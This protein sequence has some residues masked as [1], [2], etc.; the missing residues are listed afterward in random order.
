VADKSGNYIIPVVIITVVYVNYFHV[1]IINRSV[2]FSHST[3]T[4]TILLQ[5]L[6][7]HRYFSE[8]T[9]SIQ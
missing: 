1:T 3:D 2:S 9:I 7:C 8:T 4:Q 6:G 5:K